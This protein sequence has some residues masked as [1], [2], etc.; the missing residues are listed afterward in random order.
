M[1]HLKQSGVAASIGP[2]YKPQKTYIK[3][4]IQIHYMLR[5]KESYKTY[6]VSR[7]GGIKKSLRTIFSSEE[8]SA[9]IRIESLPVETL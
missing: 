4:Q 1:K 3:L 6:M 2:C 7:L 5:V 9:Y 8:V